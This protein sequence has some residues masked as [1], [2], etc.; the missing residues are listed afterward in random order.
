M[1]RFVGYLNRRPYLWLV[2]LATRSI[3]PA[4]EL[5]DIPQ[6]IDEV[7]PLDTAVAVRCGPTWFALEADLSGKGRPLTDA[8]LSLA[9]RR[10]VSVDWPREPSAHERGL[11]VP[12]RAGRTRTV[13]H[14]EIAYWRPFAT[15]AP[16]RQSFAVAGSRTPFVPPSGPIFSGTYKP[17]PSVL[18]LVHVA[19]ATVRICE[20]TFDDFCY[21]PA[22]LAGGKLIVIGA[23]FEPSRLYTVRPEERVL[24][25][26]Q[27]KRHA[28]MPLLDADLLPTR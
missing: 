4:A 21:P 1:S 25:S 27:L 26:V 20:G 16:D 13:T 7:I 5:R 2:D 23:P 19:D 11:V 6:G 14:P 3:E 8:E 28:P 18:A 12:D 9:T 15:W 22:W 10:S 24:R 17:E